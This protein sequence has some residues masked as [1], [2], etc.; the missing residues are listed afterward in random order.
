MSY[1]DTTRA[2]YAGIEAVEGTE[3]A[4]MY[5]MHTI[6]EPAHTLQNGL[7]IITE[8][9]GTRM[10]DNAS[11]RGRRASSIRIQSYIRLN[12]L[13]IWLESAIGQGTT[14]AAVSN[15]VQTVTITGTPTGGD[16]L[17]LVA[18]NPTAAIAYNAAAADV[19]AALEAIPQIGTGGVTSATGGPLPGTPVVITFATAAGD[20]YLMTADGTGLT[21]GTSPAV[22]VTGQ[23]L[24][25][26]YQRQY[27][28]GV[29]R[30][31]PMSLKFYNGLYWRK[32]L[33]CR[34]NTLNLQTF[35]NQVAQI[36]ME[37]IGRASSQISAPTPIA[38]DLTYEP[39]D[40]PM[41]WVK[42]DGLLNADVDR[43]SVALTNNLAQRNTMDKSTSAGRTRFGDFGVTV[44]GMADYPQYSGSLYEAFENN[45]LPGQM[46]LVCVDDLKTIGTPS[47][48]PYLVYTVPQPILADTSE[49]S[50]GGELVQMIKGRGRYTP[51]SAAGLIA[52]LVNDKAG[53][54]Y[55]AS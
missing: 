31:L 53:S 13:G 17:L 21:G 39:L 28:G 19:L 3:A 11:A 7:V 42:F 30:G 37:I 2:V 33:G 45:T 34:V 1:P 5:F 48:N 46:D 47:V 22:A 10:H 40:M 12:E 32:M 54:Y 14:T 20:T 4:T 23:A 29:G 43:M 36:D 24:T 8:N 25:G 51:S 26:V 27:K 35:G 18:G 41:Q 44:D 16:F 15:K 6:N 9:T 49:G 50:D 38:E 55:A 52:T